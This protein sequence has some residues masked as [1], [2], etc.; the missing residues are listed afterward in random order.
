VLL[1]GSGSGS[2]SSTSGASSSPAPIGPVLL[3]GSGSGTGS[4]TAGA[5]AVI[6][7]P[8]GLVFFVTGASGSDAA[9]SS[10]QQGSGGS[11]TQSPSD[12]GATGRITPLVYNPQSDGPPV[13]DSGLWT[14]N[15]AGVQFVQAADTGSG[16]GGG[17]P[18]A[19]RPTWNN[20]DAQDYYFGPRWLF[21]FEAGM[22]MYDPPNEIPKPRDELA[23]VVPTDPNGTH[24]AG[25]KQEFDTLPA[26]V[27]EKGKEFAWFMGEWYA[28]RALGAAANGGVKLLNVAGAS[29]PLWFVTRCGTVIE[30]GSVALG[31]GNRL[32]NFATGIGAQT[33]KQLVPDSPELWQS[34]FRELLNDGTT[35]FTFNLDG[36]D[37]WRGVARA[38]RGIKN[39][40]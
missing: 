5:S 22:G 19:G 31:L 18:P 33:W 21:E 32:D 35:R 38:A 20:D 28:D 13:F 40:L 24:Q 16:Q 14:E 23:G 3:G 39:V 15:V 34:K 37:V 8:G 27:A 1:G 12:S 17:N 29:L 30:R 4:S 25:R 7:V 26:Q 36:V 10:V 9:G 6:F 2:G 11:T